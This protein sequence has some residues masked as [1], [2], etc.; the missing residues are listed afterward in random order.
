MRWQN[1]SLAKRQQRLIGIVLLLAV[2]VSSWLVLQTSFYQIS[3]KD[4]DEHQPDAFMEQVHAIRF[5]ELGCLATEFFAPIMWHYPLNNTTEMTKPHFLIYLEGKQPWK[6]SALQ[7]KA[8]T[9]INRIVLWNNVLGHEAKGPHN[10][11]TSIRMASVTL[12][13]TRKYA[14]TNQEVTAEQPGVL[15]KSKG[16]QI[17]LTQR[18]IKL[19][20]KVRG[21]YEPTQ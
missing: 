12:F 6:I 8:F 15:I 5:D 10:P 4:M 1:I 7:G 11:E 16:A 14:E 9:G 3:S 13:P 18:T 20:A 17:D 19:L 21:D 2:I